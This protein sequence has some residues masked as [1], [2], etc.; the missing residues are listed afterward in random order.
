MSR[1]L[2]ESSAAEPTQNMMMTHSDLASD[3]ARLAALAAAVLGLGC[4]AGLG[5]GLI[6]MRRQIAWRAALR[7]N[8]WRPPALSAATIVILIAVTQYTRLPPS[9]RPMLTTDT[10][11]EAVIPLA[12]AVQAALALSPHDEPSLELILAA[13]RPTHW[14]V[15]ERTLVACALQAG[16]AAAGTGLILIV[17]GGPAE[18]PAV[19]AWLPA[20]LFLSGVSLFITLRSRQPAMGIIIATLVWFVTLVGR[21][22]IV[23]AAMGGVPFPEPLDRLQPALWIVHPYLRPGLSTPADYWLN[24]VLLSGAGC[25]LF[26][27]ALWQLRDAERLL[28]GLRPVRSRAARRQR[29]I[30]QVA[31][32]Q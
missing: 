8:G 1:P 24:R 15:L 19:V 26:A 7:R 3:W 32:A 17:T 29:R 25:G 6:R 18:W 4:A 28:L 27:L 21:D 5:I 30:P 23:P 11:V 14:V 13:P 2:D 20:T 16:V 9:V 10:V 22:V 31:S 12:I